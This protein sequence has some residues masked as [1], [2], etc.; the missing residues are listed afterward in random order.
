MDNGCLTKKELNVI[1]SS[2]SDLSNWLSTIKLSM[3]AMSS[4]NI[5]SPTCYSSAYVERMFR[6]KTRESFIQYWNSE[7]NVADV[8]RI[9]KSKL[10]TY[11]MF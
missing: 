11:K 3:K 4:D 8:N 10:C 2:Q 7:L 1:E 6:E 9:R 5:F